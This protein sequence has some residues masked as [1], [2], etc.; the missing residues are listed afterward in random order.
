MQGPLG[1]LSALLGS[2]L[3]VLGAIM[4]FSGGNIPLGLGMM[5]VGAAALA[6]PLAVNWE[7]IISALQGPIGAVVALLSTS[8]LV[9]GAILA[10]SGAALPL[11]IGLMVVGA[12]GLATTIAA[13]WDYIVA[14]LQGPIGIITAI[15]SSALLVLGGVLAFS[16]ANVPLG[17]A[18][19]VAGAAGLATSIAANWET[20]QNLLQ[21][22]VG[23][24]T[25]IIS[26]ALLVLGAILTFSGA[27]LPLA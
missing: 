17:I 10:F 12:V 9:I 14:A 27:A 3:L 23:V 24:I 18:L 11:G 2:A 7:T 21:G 15:L 22:P 26:S 6:M 13:N 5:A 19:M 1:F 16:G 25:A 20:I 8:L 4:T